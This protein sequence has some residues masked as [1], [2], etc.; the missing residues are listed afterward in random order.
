MFILLHNY[1]NVVVRICF[2]LSSY[3]L[4]TKKHEPRSSRQLTK[5]F[6]RENTVR[7]KLW[8]ALN[9][10]LSDMQRIFNNNLSQG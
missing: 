10:P 2:S 9:P 1:K 6:R 4:S 7:H 5:V 3:L 8:H